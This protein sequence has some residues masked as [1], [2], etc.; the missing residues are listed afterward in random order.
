M[1]V[2]KLDLRFPYF[3]SIML[4][5]TFVFVFVFVFV[6]SLSEL[7]VMKLGLFT[8]H[9]SHCWIKNQ[10]P[11]LTE[12]QQVSGIKIINW[13]YQQTYLS[14]YVKMQN[15]PSCLHL[16]STNALKPHLLLPKISP[17]LGSLL[18][19]LRAES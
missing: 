15:M 18:V 4:P 10:D 5:L 8:P 6:F 7:K 14:N 3:L 2:T 13:E 9:S 19:P 17:H 1:L 11:L 12:A 16:R